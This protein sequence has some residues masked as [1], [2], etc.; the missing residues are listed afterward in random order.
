MGL[1]VVCS[2]INVRFMLRHFFWTEGG[3]GLYTVLQNLNFTS[4]LTHLFTGFQVPPH[5]H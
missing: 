2:D 5:F 3:G 1:F 4:S